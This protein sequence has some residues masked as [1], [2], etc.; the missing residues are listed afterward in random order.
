LVLNRCFL[1]KKERFKQF[2]GNSTAKE[3]IKDTGTGKQYKSSLIA[4]CPFIKKQSYQPLSSDFL[5]GSSSA[6]RDFWN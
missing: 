5:V 4:L 3:R 2:L 1:G 6:S